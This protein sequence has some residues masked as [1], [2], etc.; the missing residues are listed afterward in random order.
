MLDTT[1]RTID[2]YIKKGRIQT[3]KIHKK[4]VVLRLDIMDIAKTL[5]QNKEKHRPDSIQPGTKANL[6]DTKIVKKII[7]N[8][9]KPLLN[10]VGAKVFAETKDYLEFQNI[11]N[12]T[13]QK[14]VL[15]YAIAS[16]MKDHY[17][18]LAH[19]TQDKL[20]FDIARQFQSEIQHYEKELG[21]TPAALV[22][23]KGKMEDS[24]E[25]EVDPMEALIND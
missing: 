8:P 3:S 5:T 18:T 20:F 4:E 1:V 15:R 2:R 24:E 16:Q 14:T 13:T 6:S 9:S 12:L 25:V 7:Q 11:L 21:L 17:L 22:K 23:I 19:E 10:D